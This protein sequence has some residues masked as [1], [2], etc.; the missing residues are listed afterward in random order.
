VLILFP[1]VPATIKVH[2]WYAWKLLAVGFFAYSFYCAFLGIHYQRT[3][4]TWQLLGLIV[5]T[6][7]IRTQWLPDSF[8]GHRNVQIGSLFYRYAL[9]LAYFQHIKQ[10]QLDYKKLSQRLIKVTESIYAS[11]G[12]ELHDGIGQH[13]A[14]MRLQTRL[15]RQGNKNLHLAHIEAELEHAT[16][17]LRRTLKGLHPALI[18]NQPLE[19]AVQKEADHLSKLHGTE[20]RAETTPVAL[21]KATEHQMFRIFQ[22]TVNNALQHAQASVIDVKLYRRDAQVILRVSDNGKGFDIRKRSRQ[23]PGTKSHRLG[24]ISLQERVALLN[25]QMDMQSR[26]GKGTCIQ[27]TVTATHPR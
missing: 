7:S 27:I 15:A 11:L 2:A 8:F 6:L 9:L 21:D 17:T 1:H 20:I 5:F 4:A 10:I 18:N 16:T 3:G 22:E 13:L 19:I 23:T 12:R 25:G 14:S 26:P 24:L